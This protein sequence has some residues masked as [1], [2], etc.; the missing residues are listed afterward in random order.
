MGAARFGP[1]ALRDGSLRLLAWVTEKRKSAPLDIDY[2]GPG[3]SQNHV[4]QCFAIKI[5]PK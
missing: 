1:E 2:K 3:T 4:R 5:K